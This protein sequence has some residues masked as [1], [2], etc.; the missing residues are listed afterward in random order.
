MITQVVTGEQQVLALAA[1]HSATVPSADLHEQPSEDQIIPVSVVGD[2]HCR[3]QPAVVTARV[4]GEKPLWTAACRSW[5]R[6]SA[7]TR[8]S[9]LPPFTVIKP[10]T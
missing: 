4:S 2:H 9:E 5:R 6:R 3:R 10:V 1:V 8:P 7:P